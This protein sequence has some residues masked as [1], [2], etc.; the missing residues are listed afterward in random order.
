LAAAVIQLGFLASHT[1]DTRLRSP[2]LHRQLGEGRSL[3]PDAWPERRNELDG[4]SRPRAVAPPDY[5][6]FACLPTPTLM[7]RHQHTVRIAHSLGTTRKRASHRRWLRY[8]AHQ[9][10]SGP[11]ALRWSLRRRLRIANATPG[12]SCTDPYDICR[13]L[14]RGCGERVVPTAFTLKQG[15]VLYDPA[16]M[17]VVH[18]AANY[19]YPQAFRQRLGPS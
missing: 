3:P 8:S 14:D 1:A 9:S 16:A 13:C 6:R 4:R 15:L 18:R 5:R 12:T 2:L 19:G 10:R 7:V 17:R 11:H